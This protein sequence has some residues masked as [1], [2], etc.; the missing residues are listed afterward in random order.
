MVSNR[1]TLN[2]IL[3]KKLNNVQSQRDF[4]TS[5]H[6]F[7]VVPAGRRSG[8]TMTGKIRGRR[9][10]LTIPH[11]DGRVVFAAPTH[12]QA[13]RVFWKHVK[14][15]FKG[16]TV[17][18]PLEGELSLTL[19]TGTVVEVIGLDVPER[20]EGTPLDHI[21][22]DEFAN[23]KPEVWTEHVRPM[24]SEAGREGTADF[25]GTPE[26]RNHFYNLYLD[27]ISDPNWG[28]FTWSSEEVLDPEEVLRLQ[29]DLDE[30]TYQQEI[31]AA[32]VN[33]EGLAYYAFNREKHIGQTEYDPNSPIALCLDFNAKPGNGSVIQE[34]GTYGTQ[35]IGEVFINRYSNTVEVCEKFLSDWKDH[36]SEVHLYG[37]P[38]GNQKKSSGVLGT[39]WDLAR[40]TLKPIFKERLRY[41]V[42]RSAPSIRD[43]IN[44]VNS[45]IST[46]NFRVDSKC[47]WMIRDLEGTERNEQ[48]EIVKKQGDLLTH[49]TDGLRYYM[50]RK[51]PIDRVKART[52]SIM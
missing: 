47:E 11:E 21:H 32:F 52:V 22:L 17:G 6:R 25:T 39:D 43:S 28:S 18:K 51:H 4:L 20:I 13:K 9:R 14:S 12:R 50:H 30:L 29:H 26:G 2:G 48:G 8:K 10:A 44:T 24:L 34:H 27:S 15:M 38:A 46:D 31:K 35:V 16:F 41:R 37:D 42:D 5:P 33:F 23:M 36:K 49:L 40:N 1:N 3:P 45:R 7:N 19:V